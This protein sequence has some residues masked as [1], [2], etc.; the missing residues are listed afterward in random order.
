V[1]NRG[2][3][4]SKNR[5]TVREIYFSPVSRPAVEQ[6]EY[7]RHFF[8]SIH[9]PN[10]IAKSTRA[11]RLDD[12]NDFVHPVLQDLANNVGCLNI[13]DVG[14]SSGITTLEWLEYLEHHA[15]ACQMTGSDLTI[16]AFLIDCKGFGILV[17]SRSNV[18]QIDCP[19]RSIQKHD[20]VSIDAIRSGL[21]KIVSLLLTS[22]FKGQ[23]KKVRSI[24]MYGLKFHYIS[25]ISQPLQKKA[26]FLCVEED[27]ISN[28][29]AQLFPKQWHVIRAANILNKSY[30]SDHELIQGV[31]NLRKRLVT[32][33]LL[34]I[35]RTHDGINN[36]TIFRLCTE[37]KF[38]VVDR[39]RAGSEIEA[40]VMRV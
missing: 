19:T 14:I 1:E 13:M 17:D 11:S 22:Q 7:E 12:L 36:A 25:F 32:N 40:L 39:L 10:G 23:L 37:G 29:S 18:L 24:D 16:D 35:N 8:R 15:I 34:I 4:V 3:S 9:L 28:S 2:Q 5:P 27:F 30:F 31:Q 33:G 6:N 38:E 21:K 20:S 26:N